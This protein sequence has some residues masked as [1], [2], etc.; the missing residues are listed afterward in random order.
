MSIKKVIGWPLMA[1]LML[2]SIN[3]DAQRRNNLNRSIERFEIASVAQ[4]S[5]FITTDALGKALWVTRDSAVQIL[6]LDFIPNFFNASLTQTQS[7]I[8]HISISGAIEIEGPAAWMFDGASSWEVDSWAADIGARINID[9]G[10]GLVLQGMD[11]RLEMRANQ[12]FMETDNTFFQISDF[13]SPGRMVFRA[14]DYRFSD[15]V[16][17]Q[18]PRLGNTSDSLATFD[19]SG[20]LRHI[21]ISSLPISNIGYT[22]AKVNTGATW[23]D[24]KTIFKQSFNKGTGLGANDPLIVKTAV[25]TIVRSELNAIGGSGSVIVNE[26]ATLTIGTTDIEVFISSSFDLSIVTIWFTEP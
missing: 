16:G 15:G 7:S 5:G 25:S 8:K 20:F 11:T 24:G 26:D 4:D 23:H 13:G 2:I 6:G 22:F 12:I 3:A 19:A 1:L 10:T 9:D 14:N 17:G 18:F 21:P